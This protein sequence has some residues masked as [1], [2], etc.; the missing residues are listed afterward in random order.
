MVHPAATMVDEN[1][2]DVVICTYNNAAVLERVLHG[3]AAQRPAPGPWGVLVVNNNCSDGTRE[4]VQRHLRSGA[5]P[6]LRMVDEP[7]QGLTPARR[8]GVHATSA[9]WI[10]FVDDDCLLEPDW[11]EHAMTFARSHP[12]CGGFGGRVV[13]TYATAPPPFMVRYGWVFAEQDLGESAVAVDCLVGA[14][15]VLNRCALEE[16]GWPDEPYFDDRK[17]SKL[18]SGGDVEIALRVAGTGRALWFTPGCEM[19]HVVPARRLSTAYLMRM[20]CGL[21]ISFSLA[22]A[23]TWR[24][25]R[26]SWARAVVHDL[27]TSLISV[28]RTVKQVARRRR[29]WQDAALSGSYECGRWIGAAR[30][31]L[32]LAT[33]RCPFFGAARPRKRD[34][35]SSSYALVDVELTRPPPCIELGADET[36]IG[37]VSRHE[38]RVVGFALHALEPGTCI[39]SAEIAA[40]LDPAPVPPA[41]LDGNVS[42][43]PSITVAVCTRDRPELLALCLASL[44]AQN[45][46][47]EEILVVD[48]VPT[49]DRTW[50]LAAELGVRYEREPCPGLDFA[51]NRALR[52]ACGEVV[53]FVDDDVVADRHWVASGRSTWRQHPDAGAVTG[54]ILPVELATGAQVA[55]ERRGGFRGG[56]EQVRY[57]GD[58]LDGN[59]IY[60]YGPGMFGAGANLAVRRDVALRLGGF[61]EALDTGPPL[62]GGGDLDMMHRVIRSGHALVYEPRAVVFH[63]HRRDDDGLRRQYESWGQSLMAWAVKTYWNDAAGRRKLRRLGRWFFVTQLRDARRGATGGDTEAGDAA[64]AE[65]RGGVAGVLGTYGRSQRRSLRRRRE[66][67]YPTVAILPWGDVVEDYIDPIGLSVED[68]CDRLTGGWLFGF[69]E[70]L[71]HAGVDSVIICW[72]RSVA[73][74]T[75]R[76]HLPTGAVLWLLPPSRLYRAAR[77]LLA[78]PYAW[79]WRSGIG[80]RR[81]AAAI[82]ATVARVAAPYL[83]STPVPLARVLRR[84]VCRAILCQEYEEGRFDVC[85]GI[86]RVLRLPVFATFQ[87]GDHTRTRME[88]AMRPRS[89][90]SA[91]GLIIG[92]DHEAERVRKRYGVPPDRIARVPNPLDPATVR[93]IPRATARAALGLDP[94]VRVA[95]WH[96]RVDVGPKGLDTLVEAWREVRTSCAAP[97]T[98][99][100]LGTGSGAPWLRARVDELGLDDV[101]WRNEYVLDR[102]VVGTYLSAGDV[103]VLPSRQEGFP[104]APLEAMAAGLPV[105]A[106]DAPGVRAVVGEGA[107]AGGVVVPRDDPRALARELRRLLDDCDLSAAVGDHAARRAAELFS[108]KAVGSRLRAFLLEQ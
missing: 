9:P 58:H 67:G 95:V 46:P 17:G 44:L 30:V 47:P 85:V 57:V 15:M 89:V 98:L 20:T 19:Q 80:E 11:I 25:S 4:V 1:E 76:V 33:G 22:H 61:D 74:P 78:D 5:V 39:G 55:F 66:H 70:A 13:P 101:R 31:A 26:R 84:E 48:N 100:L 28:L 75:R 68:Y 7:T 105:V 40:L 34:R 103:F 91:A 2:L 16:S 108:L 60:P 82:P 79:T 10:A 87:G 45:D 51:R 21:G 81:G 94:D 23:L 43:G 54:Q 42:G 18:I 36:G 29:T 27:R 52:F 24:G 88:R 90:R 64:L 96:G 69:T 8:C 93:R 50:E 63:R 3:L 86:G 41:V 77:R 92:A 14:G 99:L 102:D 104:V 62:P 71:Q 59:A 6:G 83:T 73:R 107:N 97:P 38:G 37:L 106:S 35:V 56:N 49:D 65:L 53:A 72:S 12:S 32:L